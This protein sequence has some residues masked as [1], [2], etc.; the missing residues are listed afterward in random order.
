LQL[1]DLVPN[2]YQY[3]DGED[4]DEDGHEH[5]DENFLVNVMYD[6]FGIVDT[7][8]AAADASIR[9]SVLA[10]N[11]RIYERNITQEL[12][13]YSTLYRSSRNC[14]PTGK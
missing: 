6:D 5:T 2:L 9:S 7:V 13:R 8:V 1:L 14:S 11:H 4:E 3:G 10:T 12:D